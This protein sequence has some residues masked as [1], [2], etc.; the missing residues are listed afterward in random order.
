MTTP[1]Y[2]PA[3][4]EFRYW[5]AIFAKSWRPVLVNSVVNPVLFL[6]GI[7]LGL[8]GLVDDRSPLDGGL[9]YAA[10]FAPGLLAAAAMQTAV[11]EGGQAVFNAVRTRRSYRVA[12]YTPLQPHDILHGHLLFIAV[13]ILLSSAV[14]VAVMY[15]FAIPASPGAALAV[16]VAVLLG[17]TCAAPTAAWAITVQQPSVI[18]NFSRFVVM[19]LYLFS[20]TF[21][22]VEVMP[23]WLQPLVYLSPLWH[24]AR[25]CRD[26]SVGTVNPLDAGVDLALLALTALAGYLAARRSYRRHL[27]S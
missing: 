13:R 6:A 2:S 19:P 16:P 5:G 18:G 4:A 25:L 22:P 1:A 15:A 14:F 8:G 21:F 23:G 10:F 24:G 9:S 20:A 27:H 26:L 11:V 17:V 3:F 7:G 12:A